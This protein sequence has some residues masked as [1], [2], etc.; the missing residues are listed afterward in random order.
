MRFN[1]LKGLLLVS[2]VV[3]TSLT[4]CAQEKNEK[5]KKVNFDYSMNPP[6]REAKVK[7]SVISSDSENQEK[8]QI[9]VSGKENSAA[10]IKTTVDK[11]GLVAE[12]D[13][14]PAPEGSANTTIAKKTREIAKR[15]ATENLPATEIYRVGVNDVLYISLQNASG[16]SAKYYTVLNDGTID[17]PLAG[18]MVSV[19]GLTSDQIEEVLREKI[20]LYEN[21][22][23]SVK[24]RE[25][26]SHSISVI[27]AVAKPGERFLQREAMPL[28]VIRAEALVEPEAT[29]VTIKRKDSETQT[30]EMSDDKYQNVLIYP[31]DIVEFIKE[32][33]KTV[34]SADNFY[35]IGGFVRQAGRKEYFEGITLT[36]AILASSGLRESRIRNI[37]IRRKN[38]DGL[39]ESQKYDL[40]DIKDGKIPDPV[41]EPGDTIESNY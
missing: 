10:A 7:S 27:G 33:P 9:G 22:E 38:A 31:G 13:D 30:F 20:K 19:I 24:V 15:A 5:V 3:G 18:E 12:I 25:H 26:A 8:K 1:V 32:D 11:D 37:T 23:V 41:I 4:V 29:R 28:F 16:D 35:F 34:A 21:P 6:V 2:V 39:L 14:N 17:Y 36:Q 40:K